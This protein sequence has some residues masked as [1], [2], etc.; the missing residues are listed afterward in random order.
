MLP[1]VGAA[2]RR[3]AHPERP[4]G[5]RVRIVAEPLGVDLGVRAVR[6][7]LVQSVVDGVAQIVVA[8]LDPDAVGLVGL[9]D[10]RQLHVLLVV[11]LDDPLAH[12]EVID[13]G[14]DT[15]SL[16]VLEREQD[17]VVLLQVLVVL[18][19]RLLGRELTG[20]VDL[21]SD[22]LALQA[23]HVLDVA[24]LGHRDGLVGQ[25]VGVGRIHLL[26]ALVRDGHR[27]HDHVVLAGLQAGDDA[28]PGGGGDFPLDAELLGDGVAEVYVEALGHVALLALE[29]RVR[30]V[31]AG[32]DDAFL[33][34]GE[35]HLGLVLVGALCRL[36]TDH[37]R[38][39]QRYGQYGSD[40]YV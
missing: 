25:D 15:P 26:L 31:G 22:L 29:R 16:E 30:R 4:E 40:P 23:I 11:V 13:D 7:D 28:V 39:D 32:L 20:G 24:A 6:D 9:D 38:P 5:L 14:V 36:T 3:A 37:H 2:F 12:R 35:L 27:G 34:G 17:V 1:S 33:D 21:D 10:R 8:L 19:Q 18:A